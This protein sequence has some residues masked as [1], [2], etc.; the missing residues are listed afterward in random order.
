MT[1]QG[2]VQLLVAI[3]PQNQ[4]DTPDVQVEP[5]G[6]IKR[7]WGS[8]IQLNAALGGK[9]A[10]PQPIAGLTAS[11]QV[12]V[13]QYVRR[14]F[15]ISTAALVLESSEH[16][17]K[18]GVGR[19]VQP[20]VSTLSPGVFQFSTNWG[21]LIHAS[22]GAHVSKTFDR[23]LAQVGAGRPDLVQANG[24]IAPVAGAAPRAPFVEARV[25]YVDPRFMGE[26]PS[27]AVIG[28]RPAPLTLGLTGAIGRQRVGIG[29]RAA[30]LAASPGAADP[31]VED[32]TSWIASAEAI[33]PYKRL[34]LAGEWYFGRGANAYIGAVRQRP[35]VDP[36]TGRHTALTSSGGWVQ[37]SYSLPQRWKVV[38]VAGLERVT[39]GLDA[40]VAVDGTPSISA[41]RLVALSISKNFEI[42]MHAGVQLQRQ[43][44]E[45]R[46]LAD[47]AMTSVLLESSIDF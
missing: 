10:Y 43:S 19:F 30:V 24:P 21:N 17:V 5:A 39:G 23:V 34:V 8:A 13:V 36:S 16:G 44:T 33:V 4:G 25:A 14:L 18:I 35:Y 20:T 26:L 29:E 1:L 46:A 12:L 7:E 42:G 3:D 11:G 28:A 47:G 40:G 32:V 27:G 31:R 9:F 6:S 45:Y 2:R 22:T 37:L 15:T 38:G 41:N